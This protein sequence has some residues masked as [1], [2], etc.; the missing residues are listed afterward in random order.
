VLQHVL[1]YFRRLLDER[2]RR[3]L[4]ALVDDYGRGLLPLIVPITL[5]R[6][7]VDRLGIEYL[8]GQVYLEPHPKELMLRNRV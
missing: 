4:A 8:A 5:I 6:H 2:D 1:G 7:H 3:E